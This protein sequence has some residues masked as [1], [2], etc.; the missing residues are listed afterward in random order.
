[1][2][3]RNKYYSD[4]REP[5]F[6]TMPIPPFDGETRPASFVRTDSNPPLKP[7]MG[8][9]APGP[10]YGLQLHCTEGHHKGQTFRFKHGF[11]IKGRYRPRASE[12]TLYIPDRFESECSFNINVLQG[13]GFIRCFILSSESIIF[14]GEALPVWSHVALPFEDYA[15][16]KIIHN[17]WGEKRKDA[18]EEFDITVFEY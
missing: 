7:L 4:D 16:L 9:P 15:H 8:Y 3:P 2:A 10:Y 18:V 12:D 6:E 14:N 5:P 13:G 11:S 1:M 17:D